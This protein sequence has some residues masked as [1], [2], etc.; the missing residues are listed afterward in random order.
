M[1]V[2]HDSRAP[3][4][5]AAVRPLSAA[6]RPRHSALAALILVLSLL[7]VG[8]GR[9]ALATPLEPFFGTYVGVAEVQDLETGATQ[10]RHM[11]IVIE[12]YRETGFRLHWINVTL[13]D[14]RRD[15]PG[16]ER[17]V[18][19]VLFE[20]AADRAFYVE[21]QESNPFR[22]R[23]A[24][25]P[26]H[27]DPVRWAAVED[28]RLHVYSFVVLEDGRYELQTYD[29]NLTEEGMNIRFERILDGRV[30]K[31]I[32]GTTARARLEVGEG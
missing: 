3:L 8:C 31:R 18:Q 12:P 11:D 23:S 30:V 21:A 15:L 9:T 26:M 28:G 7:T 29:R 16:V 20:P 19:T 6:V 1:S 17:Q 25:R 27:G 22:E 2:M 4:L 24:T 13:V 10:Q 32:T 5:S 14:G